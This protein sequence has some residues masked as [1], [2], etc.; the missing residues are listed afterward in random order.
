MRVCIGFQGG[1]WNRLK[2]RE[3]FGKIQKNSEKFR[4]IP[5]NS[6]KIGKI[7]KNSEKF[8][9]KSGKIGEQNI[10]SGEISGVWKPRARSARSPREGGR[11][12]GPGGGTYIPY[13][14]STNSQGGVQSKNFSG[15]GVVLF[16][17]PRGG[18]TRSYSNLNSCMILIF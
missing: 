2:I 18:Y 9:K 5:K 10:K 6:E 1:V 4:K 8:G 13:I 11:T 15:G 12:C 14:P 3:K 7:Q 17:L 16:F